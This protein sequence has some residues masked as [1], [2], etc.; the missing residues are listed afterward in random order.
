LTDEHT[1]RYLR[2]EFWTPRLMDRQN[3]T[4]WMAQG[5]KTILDR[6]I[7]R[8][9]RILR[10]H[11]PDWISEELEQEIDRIVAVADRELR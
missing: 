5:A 7:E 4:T 8:R 10:E 11:T 3:Y 6:A 1:L 2:Q 9:D